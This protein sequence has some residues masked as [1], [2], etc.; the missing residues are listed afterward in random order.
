MIIWPDITAGLLKRE[1]TQLYVLEMASGETLTVLKGV[2]IG[3]TL[4]RHL[5]QT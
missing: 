3:L 4:L 1:L 5:Q 2:L